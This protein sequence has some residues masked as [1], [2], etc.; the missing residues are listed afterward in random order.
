MLLVDV[1]HLCVV[2][3]EQ[4]ARV[5]G[6]AAARQVEVGAFDTVVVHLVIARRV[7]QVDLF[8]TPGV[9][10]QAADFLGVEQGPGIGGGE[11]ARVVVGGYRQLRLQGA[12]FQHAFRQPYFG[13]Q[14]Q[15]AI[16]VFR[17]LAFGAEGQQA[18]AATITAGVEFDRRF[19]NGVQAQA[20][21]AFGKPRFNACGKTL[22][23]F[24]GLC[25]RRVA[26]PEVAV[27]V[28]VAGFEAAFAVFDKA[29]H[30]RR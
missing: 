26:L 28:H 7:A 19:A 27:H 20:Q 15:F 17:F 1:V 14:P 24:F 9:E 8:Q 10:G 23:P 25:L 5:D 4:Q 16:G 11:Q 13:G 21:N 22:R 29:G 30:G 18:S 3:A 6:V 2:V 12:D